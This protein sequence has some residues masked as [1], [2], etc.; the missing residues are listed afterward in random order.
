MYRE[1]QRILNQLAAADV[2]RITELT[3][4]LRPVRHYVAFAVKFDL[5]DFICQ[6]KLVYIREAVKNYLADFLR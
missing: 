5:K 2:K 3:G 4:C 6:L 1:Y